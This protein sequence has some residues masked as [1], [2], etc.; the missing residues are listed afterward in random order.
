MGLFSRAKNKKG[1]NYAFLFIC[2]GPF[3]S[4]GEKCTFIGRNDENLKKYVAQWGYNVP[5]KNIYVYSEDWNDTYYSSLELQMP[6]EYDDM[7]GKVK[8]KLKDEG[9]EFD[10]T[11]AFIGKV[12]F[13]AGTSYD[14]KNLFLVT[15]I[16]S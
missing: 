11:K 14:M 13:A 4:F 1:Q 16:F 3:S 8:K 6:G 5:E 12:A 7:I 15:V 10:F 9:F 2:H